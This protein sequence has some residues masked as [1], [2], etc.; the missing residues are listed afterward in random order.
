MLNTTEN[1]K[2]TLTNIA[3]MQCPTIS[4]WWLINFSSELTN[5]P[6]CQKSYN[7]LWRQ[8]CCMSP[9]LFN[10]YICLIVERWLARRRWS[11]HNS[12]IISM[13]RSCLEG[14]LGM[15]WWVGWLNAYLL[16]MVLYCLQQGVVL[17]LQCVLTSN[18]QLAKDKT[19][20]YR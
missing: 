4:S 19:H 16:T 17:R 10:L 18:S 11:T 7:P 8:G 1:S 14:T 6:S 15:I 3:S 13:F 9:V 5:V 20:G 2:C 12:F